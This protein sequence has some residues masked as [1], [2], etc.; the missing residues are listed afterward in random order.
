[1]VEEKLQP[2]VNEGQEGP[3]LLEGDEPPYERLLQPG[4]LEESCGETE[5]PVPGEPA[6]PGSK[7]KARAAPERRMTAPAGHE[8]GCAG[9][10]IDSG[11]SMCIVFSFTSPVVLLCSFVSAVFHVFPLPLISSYVYFVCAFSFIPYLFF[12]FVSMSCHISRFINSWQV[13]VF[14]VSHVRFLCSRSHCRGFLCLDLA[15]LV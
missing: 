9:Y 10:I 12:W 1:M 14:Q 8:Q 6:R 7:V 5:V 15:L 11:V 13:F 3:C 2:E 4:A